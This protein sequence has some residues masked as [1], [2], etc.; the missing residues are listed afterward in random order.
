MGDKVEIKNKPVEC[1]WYNPGR[2]CMYQRRAYFDRQDGVIPP[3]PC[4][5]KDFKKK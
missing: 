4:P 2:M 5:C 3:F 1:G